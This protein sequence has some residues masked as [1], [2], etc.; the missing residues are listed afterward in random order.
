MEALAVRSANVR[1]AAE[2]LLFNTDPG[3]EIARH[4]VHFVDVPETDPCRKESI[5]SLAE[6]KK[7]VVSLIHQFKDHISEDATDMLLRRAIGIGELYQ[8][9]SEEELVPFSFILESISHKLD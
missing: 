9:L 4:Y 7:I 5:R 6:A 3:V 8:N 1:D 2:D